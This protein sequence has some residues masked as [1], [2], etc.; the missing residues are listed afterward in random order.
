MSDRRGGWPNAA[1]TGLLITVCAL[2]APAQPAPAQPAPPEVEPT[3]AVAPAPPE[4]TTRPAGSESTDPPPV[5]PQAV[6]PTPAT[7]ARPRRNFA[8]RPDAVP[9][10]GAARDA[11]A[12]NIGGGRRGNDD[13]PELTLAAVAPVQIAHTAQ[14]Q[15]GFFVHLSKPSPCRG[16]FTLTRDG[17]DLPEHRVVLQAPL[18]AGFHA[19]EAGEI[20]A[21][22]DPDTVYEWTFALVPAGR[23]RSTSKDLVVGGLI[24]RVLADT[25]HATAVIDEAHLR[26]LQRDGLTHD[27]LETL[28]RI[29]ADSSY[30]PAPGVDP[31]ACRKVV[32]ERLRLTGTS[33]ADIRANPPAA[34]KR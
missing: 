34:Q 29:V 6:A 9:G 25:P 5:D 26:A 23:A 14:A 22:L 1:M 27:Y 30:V 8:L 11:D 31:H 12:I 4:P 18:R 21:T 20:G 16:V 13:D 28:A 7:P 2:P 15:P 33:P 32:L 3:G 24:R 19:I 10:Q 17:S